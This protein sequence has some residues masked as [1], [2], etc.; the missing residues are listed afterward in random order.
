[1]NSKTSNQ[2][3]VLKSEYH[4]LIDGVVNPTQK[5]LKGLDQIL[6]QEIDR[7]PLFAPNRNPHAHDESIVKTL[8]KNMFLQTLLIDEIDSMNEDIRQIGYG[9]FDAAVAVVD[10]YSETQGKRF[11][12]KFQEIDRQLKEKQEIRVRVRKGVESKLD[13][14]VKKQEAEEKAEMNDR[15]KAKK[16]DKSSPS[17]YK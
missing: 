12:A 1:M 3:E 16:R 13:K 10:G 5:S 15:R 14:W 17:I 7:N 2:I 9:I 6:E 8:V 4:K 11:R